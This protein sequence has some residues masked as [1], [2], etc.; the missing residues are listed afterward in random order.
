MRAV[1]SASVSEFSA[2]RQIQKILVLSALIITAGL[3]ALAQNVVVSPA[4]LAFPSQLI[5]TTS[6]SKAVTRERLTVS[7]CWISRS[8]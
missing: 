1:V 8:R 3:S 5:N 6:G 2:A 7:S 4:S